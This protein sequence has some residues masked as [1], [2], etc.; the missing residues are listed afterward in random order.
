VSD[1]SFLSH[2]DTSP[3]STWKATF[4]SPLT[5]PLSPLQSLIFRFPPLIAFRSLLPLTIL[6]RCCEFLPS[7][8]VKSQNYKQIFKLWDF[9]LNHFVINIR[10]HAIFQLS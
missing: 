4:M 3:L 7:L 6:I 1:F 2:V 9:Q 8:C 10:L 5:T